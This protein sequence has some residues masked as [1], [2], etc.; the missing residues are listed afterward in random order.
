MFR[1]DIEL[2]GVSADALVDNVG[3]ESPFL[4]VGGTSCM[5]DRVIKVIKLMED[6]N[7][8][9]S[10]IKTVQIPDFAIDKFLCTRLLWGCLLVI[11]GPPFV[12]RDNEELSLV[13]FGKAAL[14]DA[15]NPPGNQRERD[16]PWNR[17][18]RLGGREHHQPCLHPE[19]P[20]KRQ[21]AAEIL[22]QEGLLDVKYHCI[23]FRPK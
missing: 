8:A 3:L 14:L 9:A 23:I 18:L 15:A 1:Q 5:G 22:V 19:D 17:R 2:P 6:L 10:L 12:P 20:R 4:V 7:P 16:P 13:L 11:K 21:P